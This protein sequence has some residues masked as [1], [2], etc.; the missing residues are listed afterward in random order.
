[1]KKEGE[2]QTQTQLCSQTHCSDQA[3]PTRPSH[4]SELSRLRRI[5]GQISGIER[6]IEEGRYC[7][8]I[9]VQ[10]RAVSAA[11]RSLETSLLERHINH[12]VHDA[13]LSNDDAEREAKVSE[14]IAIFA[15]RL[16][17]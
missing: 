9:L 2:T 15:K 14:L 3:E 1:M 8:D 6:M 17:R 5:S 11:I 4:R 7:P 13:F 16:E 10:T 12:C